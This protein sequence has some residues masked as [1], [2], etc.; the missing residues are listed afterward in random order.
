MDKK[1]KA[2][3]PKLAIAMGTILVLI[4]ASLTSNAFARSAYQGE[5]PP[6]PSTDHREFGPLQGP[7]DSPQEV[8]LACLS[9]HSGVAEDIM[10]TTH[11]T[12]EYTNEETG[13]VLGKKNL[14]NNF[15]IS[16][17]SNEPRCT[18]CHIGYGWKDNTFD[19][20]A[21]ENID[22]LVCHDTTGTYQKFPT[23]A[24]YPV[25]TTTEFPAGSGIFFNPPDLAN[26][27][28]NIGKTSNETC[29]ACHFYGGGGDY[30]KHGDLDSSLN[31]APYSLDVHLSADGANFN[32]TNCHQSENHQI[33]GSRYGQAE[34]DWQGCENCHTT[35]PHQLDSLNSHT[36]V[37]C[38]SCHIPAF[39]RGGNPTKMTWDWSAAGQLDSASKPVVTRNED[40][41]II[42][43]GKKGAFT[44]QYDVIPEYL[45]YNGNVSYVM[46]GEQIDPTSMVHINDFL[47]DKDDP[48]AK[49]YPV[50]AFIATQPFD[51]GN[52]TLAIP[53]L[54]GQDDA[55]YW[56]TFDWDASIQAGMEY[57]GLPYSGEYDF[58][59]SVMYWPTTHMVA[60]AEEAL[61]CQECH[62]TEGGRLDFAA[63]GYSQADVTKLTNFPPASNFDANQPNASTPR[64][65][66]VCKACHTQEH[67]LWSQSSHLDN[68]VGCVACHQLESD[69]EHPEEAFTMEKDAELCGACHINEYRDW[70]TSVHSEYNVTCVTCHNPHSQKQMTIGDY[71]ISCQT[72]HREESDIVSHSTHAAAGLLCNECHMNT[73][74]NTG[75]SWLVESDTC[76]VCHQESIHGADSIL[77]GTGTKAEPPAPVETEPSPEAVNLNL[78]IWA[79]FFS[80]VVVG[81]ALTLV[82]SRHS[83]GKNEDPENQ[84]SED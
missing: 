30:V 8:T 77:Q 46:P 61:A 71:E 23:G 1:R 20:S 40:G 62:T 7:F 82:F 60:P 5:E 42:Y 29:G 21:E 38:Q 28:Q 75:H 35:T 43:D 50:K 73:D 3:L 19:F 52:N 32:C 44:Y 65:P 16:I 68:A 53:H 17:E 33:T 14:I 36:K 63:L 11:W 48:N 15:C 41:D 58:V 76:L 39:A 66:D 80:A 22:C 24:G 59:E 49:I 9:C 12:W 74:L 25:T 6:E 2:L 72:C 69:V 67:E 51:T 70:E 13:Q 34:G 31:N 78:P 26:V 54:F 84:D 83:N 10:Q 45:W 57:A 27:A 37:A 55:A 47:G 4:S 79:A 81:T 64:D 56:R 18:S